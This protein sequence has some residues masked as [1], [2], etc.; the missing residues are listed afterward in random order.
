MKRT[1]NLHDKALSCLP[2]GGTRMRPKAASKQVL[3]SRGPK[4]VHDL[5]AGLS[6]Q[7][8]PPI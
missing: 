5:R 3:I 1:I 6:L 4:A 7:S 2:L 8:W